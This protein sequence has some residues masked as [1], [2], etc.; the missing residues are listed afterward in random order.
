MRDFSISRRMVIA[1]GAAA[2]AGLAAGVGPAAPA[3]AQPRGGAAL[4]SARLDEVVAA[5]HQRY[6]GLAEGANADYIPAL[7]A[8]PSTYFGVALVGADG[9]VHAA[10]DSEQLFSIQSI[11]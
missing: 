6:R 5:A 9:R 2:T 7:A 11:S 1:G 3:V 10:G 8:V 4:S